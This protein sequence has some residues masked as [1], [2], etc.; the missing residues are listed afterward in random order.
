M[1]R[2]LIKTSNRPASRFLPRVEALESRWCPS[3]G[4]IVQTG[5]ALVI[6][7]DGANDTITVSDNGQGGVTASITLAGELNEFFANHDRMAGVGGQATE[8]LGASGEAR[9]SATRPPGL[10]DYEIL[11][12]IARGG[13]GVVY[14]ARQVSLQRDVAL[15]MILPGQAVS[16][17]TLR[18][19]RIE[20]EAAAHLD[21]PGIVPIYEVGEHDNQPYFTMKLIEGGSLASRL[22]EYRLPGPG[23]EPRPGRRALQER[24][25]RLAGLRFLSEPRT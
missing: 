21:H 9:G 8:V 17:H 19:F 15:K 11:H 22:E 5:S 4:G 10:G 12:E 3:T 14:R 7:G 25:V 16:F 18:R 23:H 6:R 2:S 13:M 1:Y 20:A 24:C